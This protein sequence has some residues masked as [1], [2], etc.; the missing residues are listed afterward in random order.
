[1]IW[2]VLFSAGMLLLG[3]VVAAG[4]M[5]MGFLSSLVNDLHRTI[6]ITTPT[7]K[8]VRI[9]ILM[10]IVSMLIIVDGMFL[11]FRYVFVPR[12]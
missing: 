8:Q 3:G 9:A 4:W 6:G 12:V 10:W 2:I 5:P 11:L 7:P 1:M